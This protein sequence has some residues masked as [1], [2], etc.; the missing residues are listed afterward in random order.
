MMASTDP[1]LA[2]IAAKSEKES[3]YHLRHAAK[4]DT[5]LFLEDA[6]YKSFILT[7]SYYLRFPGGTPLSWVPRMNPKTLAARQGTA[8]HHGRLPCTLRAF[9]LLP[10]HFHLVLTEHQG[11]KKPGISELMRRLS[12]GY[13]MTYRQKYGGVG[14]IYQGKYKMIML[15]TDASSLA[16]HLHA[17]DGVNTTY[18]RDPLHSS[19]P[20]YESVSRP[21]LTPLE[22]PITS[23]FS[24]RLIL[25]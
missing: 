17:H 13:A 1:T 16:T 9:L 24:P 18:L 22:S 5:R 8:K 20:D 25:E 2:A 11:N 21:W 3:A 12:V 7:L 6:D 19:L 4:K 14:T 15:G 10:D 23:D